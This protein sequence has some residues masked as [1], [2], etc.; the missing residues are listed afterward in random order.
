MTT[1]T[2][3]D[4]NNITAFATAEEAAATTAT[5]FGSFASQLELVELASAWPPER[6]VAI[7]NT[8][9]GV[10]PVES[11]KSSKVAASR[12]WGRIQSLA[13]VYKLKSRGRGKYC[14]SSR[15]PGTSLYVLT[16]VAQRWTG[17][18]AL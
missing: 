5:P 18:V 8:L 14:D 4:E 15:L 7:W 9:T 16:G 1:F 3:N 17:L 12:I 11:F 6:L 2:I 10:T 13:G